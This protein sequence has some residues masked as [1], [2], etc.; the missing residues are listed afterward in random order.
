[1]PG[2]PGR[3]GT[4]VG[5]KLRLGVEQPFL[6]EKRETSKEST[7]TGSGL[8][9]ENGRETAGTALVLSWNRECATECNACTF[10]IRSC[11]GQ[12]PHRIKPEAIVNIP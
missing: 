12:D 6:G 11:W 9:L 8:L 4:V 10:P 3:G 5:R 7:Y 1:M 2:L